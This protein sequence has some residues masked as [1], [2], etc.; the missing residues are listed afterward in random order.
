MRFQPNNTYGKGRPKGS[1]N[2][3]AAEVKEKLADLT[4]EALIKL[5]IEDLETEQILRLIGYSLSYIIPK[6]KQMDMQ[7]SI[8]DTSNHLEILN[9]LTD[10][11][12]EGNFNKI[13]NKN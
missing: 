12:L 4:L 6:L 7:A 1:K 10:D 11:E 13:L 5:R 3:V 2:K 9:S 8:N